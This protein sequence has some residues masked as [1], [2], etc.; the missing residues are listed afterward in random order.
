MAKRP[1][2][3]GGNPEIFEHDPI[4]PRDQFV[5]ELVEEVFPRLAT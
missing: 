3:H 1:G 2:H 5:Y 4:E